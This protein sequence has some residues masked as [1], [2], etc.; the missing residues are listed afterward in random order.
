VSDARSGHTVAALGC[1]LMGSAVARAVS[2]AGHD[3]VVRNRTPAKA[4]ELAGDRVRAVPT[5]AEAVAAAC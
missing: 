5:A 4:E 1:G 2:R 3:L